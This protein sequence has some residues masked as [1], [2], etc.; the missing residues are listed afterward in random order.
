MSITSYKQRLKRQIA[1]IIKITTL[2]ELPR[3]IGE[4]YRYFKIY[5]YLDKLGK[6]RQK[7]RHKEHTIQ[8]FLDQ[9]RNNSNHSG[10]L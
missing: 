8:T 10:T 4:K 1:Q 5:H 6:F 3:L 7:I 2:M 9:D